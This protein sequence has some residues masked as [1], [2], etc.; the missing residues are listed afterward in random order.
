MKKEIYDVVYEGSMFKVA[1]L[2]LYS[3]ESVGKYYFE[4]VLTQPE[5]I[6][7]KLYQIYLTDEVYNGPVVS[8]HIR[9]DK[10]LLVTFGFNGSTYGGDLNKMLEIANNL[11]TISKEADS[12][13]D[14]IAQSINDL[15]S[16][17]IDVDIWND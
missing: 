5:D 11:S 10:N 2:K 16:K 8:L 1:L 7:T 3:E 6:D 12:A 15:L 14:A 13:T 17:N 9:I 4:Y